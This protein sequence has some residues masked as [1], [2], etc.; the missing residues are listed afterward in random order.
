MATR[1]QI[2]DTARTYL[3]TKF[4]HQG[5]LRGVGVDCV[6]VPVCVA[7]ELGLQVQDLQEYPRYPDGEL[8]RAALEVSLDPIALDAVLPGDIIVFKISKHLC[9][10]GLRTDYGILHAMSSL[11]RVAEHRFDCGWKM[12]ATAAYRFRGIEEELA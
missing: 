9:H 12:K 1:K 2:I 5:R 6:G 4:K 11:N 8:L 10:V 7:R 3:G